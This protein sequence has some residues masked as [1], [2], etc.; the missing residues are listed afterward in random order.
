MMGLTKK[1]VPF[2]WSTDCD[3][4]FQQLKTAFVTTPVL[5]KFDPDQQIVI[6][7]D[8]SD[9]VMGGVMS[10]YDKSGILH[11]VAY[12]S[13]KHSPTECNY[14][15]YDK[16][17]MAIIRC[18]EVWRPELEGSAFPIYILSDHKNLEYFMTTKTLSR[19][20]ARW[21]EYLSRF[22]FKIVYQYQER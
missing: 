20:Q 7:S 3:Q 17:L 14:E 16:E 12:F 19:R 22:N 13:K 11:L 9:F 2:L 4:A 18:F 1:N 15:I 10:Q 8:A 5:I 21:S 6:K